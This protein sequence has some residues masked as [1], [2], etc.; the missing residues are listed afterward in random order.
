MLRLL[1]FLAGFAVA[2]PTT[3]VKIEVDVGYYAGDFGYYR[4]FLH[5]NKDKSWVADNGWWELHSRF[6]AFKDTLAT[7]V[8]PE[9]QTFCVCVKT[10]PTW[11]T[12]MLKH[13]RPFGEGCDMTTSAHGSCDPSESGMHEPF[14]LYKTTPPTSMNPTAY[15]K[16]VIGYF[17]DPA[18]ITGEFHWLQY[19]GD[20]AM[21]TQQ[22]PNDVPSCF[23]MPPA[24]VPK[25]LASNPTV[26]DP[27]ESGDM[28]LPNGADD[29]AADFADF[30]TH[31]CAAT[32]GADGSAL[33]GPH[34]TTEPIGSAV[35]DVYY[36]EVGFE[37]DCPT[38]FWRD[39]S[40]LSSLP[41]K[42]KQCPTNTVRRIVSRNS[43]Y[44][45]GLRDWSEAAVDTADKGRTRCET[46]PANSEYSWI[47]GRV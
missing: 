45:N 4:N 15:T 40:S 24:R 10:T 27:V 11:R 18:D 14:A 17:R 37:L 31:W 28:V 2:D 22:P 32:T 6:F 43:D 39:G 26:Q 9:L 35:K 46:C 34:W 12:M 23:R 7:R 38:G 13:D 20:T 21:N 30:Q 1:P 44:Q 47:G 3:W 19:L 42:C 25:A 8:A 29:G 5:V 33:T 41:G 36:I 16:S